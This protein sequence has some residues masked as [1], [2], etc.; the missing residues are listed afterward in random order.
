MKSGDYSFRFDELKWRNEGRKLFWQIT[1][2]NTNEKD[3]QK[4][5]SNWVNK[6]WLS[7]EEFITEMVRNSPKGENN[8]ILKVIF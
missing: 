3:Y 4:S 1:P 6:N 8:L 7:A 2:I 5:I